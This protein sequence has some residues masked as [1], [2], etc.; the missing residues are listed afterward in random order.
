MLNCSGAKKMESGCL[1][2]FSPWTEWRRSQSPDAT[3]E[4]LSNY[5]IHLKHWALEEYSRRSSCTMYIYV[6]ILILIHRRRI[7]ENEITLVESLPHVSILKSSGEEA[8][9]PV[10]YVQ[11][12]SKNSSYLIRWALWDSQGP[13]GA[14]Q[15]WGNCPGVVSSLERLIFQTDFMGAEW[16]S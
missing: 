14:I 10:Q 1:R 2:T 6:P 5:I 7:R 13:F 16:K 4:R 12:Y 3:P 15:L 9:P 8:M 11:P